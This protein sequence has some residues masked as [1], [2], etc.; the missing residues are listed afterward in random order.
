MRDDRVKVSAVG[1]PMPRNFAANP[2]D[3]LQITIAPVPERL[4]MVA[5]NRYSDDV[6]ED[7]YL[8]FVLH[9]YARVLFE[10]SR[11]EHSV[12]NLPDVIDQ[13]AGMQLPESPDVF[14]LAG[15]GGG[16]TAHADSGIGAARLVFRRS[17]IRDFDLDGELV[18]TGRTLAYSILAVIQAIVPLLH[19]DSRIALLSGLANMNVSY[20]ITHRYANANSLHEVPAIAYFAAAFAQG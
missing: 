8:R 13:L 18:M 1:M 3:L 20:A 7:L 19:S 11:S 14:R 9:F 6:G 15:V 2:N 10:L 12:R 5:F 4:Y 17:G 16:L